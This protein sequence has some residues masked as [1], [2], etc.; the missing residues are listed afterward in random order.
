MSD[1]IVKAAKSW[2]EH[3]MHNPSWRFVLGNRSFKAEELVEH[4]E[5][6]TEEGKLLLEMI[7]D[8]AVDLFMRPKSS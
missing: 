8:T 3:N 1:R 4:L 6:G 2:L 5:K 7:E